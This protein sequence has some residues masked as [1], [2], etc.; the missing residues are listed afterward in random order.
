MLPREPR[1]RRLQC[2]GDGGSGG[3]GGASASAT[4]SNFILTPFEKLTVCALRCTMGPIGW[5]RPQFPRIKS[6]MNDADDVISGTD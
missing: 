2:G 1:P 5:A 3:G 4:N 6:K